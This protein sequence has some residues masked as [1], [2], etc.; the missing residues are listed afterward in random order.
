MKK[1][2]IGFTIIAA[3]VLAV[4]GGCKAKQGNDSA[5][6]V[7]VNTIHAEY[8]EYDTAQDIV[9]ASDLVFS[10]TVRTIDYQMLD[11]GS[12]M[13]QDDPEVYDESELLP[14]TLY[15]VDVEKV[16][17]GNLETSEII[18]KQLG[19]RFDNDE[20]MIENSSEIVE[21]KKYLFLTETYENTYPSLLNAAQSSY[22]MDN[23]QELRA[24]EE[25]TKITLP[26]ILSFFEEDHTN[27]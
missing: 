20:Y 15:T 5:E 11:V 9:E 6:K 1:K 18:I 17:K 27:E 24:A 7:S 21:G 10:G 13:N 12:G 8:P 19:G 4:V 25:D 2:V 16:Y 3:I 14:Y 23:V 26:K 22:E